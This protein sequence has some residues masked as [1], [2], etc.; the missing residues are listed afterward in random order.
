MEVLDFLVE[1]NC[2]VDIQLELVEWFQNNQEDDGSWCLG[3]NDIKYKDLVTWPTN[4]VVIALSKF[5]ASYRFKMPNY[6]ICNEC[7]ETLSKKNRKQIVRNLI[8][9][10]LI[11]IIIFE[12]F[13][14]VGPIKIVQDKWN[15]LPEGFRITFGITLVVALLV[16]LFSAGIIAVG[17]RFFS[18]K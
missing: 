12:T 11:I 1:T 10:S 17:K 3:A 5:L 15:G 16:N 6:L 2:C 7:A 8:I 14:L 9:P 13:L 4:E 18:N